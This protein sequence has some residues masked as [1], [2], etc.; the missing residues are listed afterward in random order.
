MNC[1][2]HLG[3]MV[4]S[5]I[6]G[7]DFCPVPECYWWHGWPQRS[8][9]TIEAHIERSEELRPDRLGPTEDDIQ[10]PALPNG[11]VRPSKTLG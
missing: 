8:S 4:P 9:F 1:P 10:D 11:A 5:P 7:L 2:E 3:E 6:D